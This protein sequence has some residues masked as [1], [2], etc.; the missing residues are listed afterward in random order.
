[1]ERFSVSSIDATFLFLAINMFKKT[2]RTMFIKITKNY[3]P[4]TRQGYP[5]RLINVDHIIHVTDLSKVEESQ[6]TRVG[7]RS[8][9]LLSNGEFIDTNYSFEDFLDFLTKR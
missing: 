7:V 3:D 6:R 9:I 8:R 1:M 4:L 5:E 2:K